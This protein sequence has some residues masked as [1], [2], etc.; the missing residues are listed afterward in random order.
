[1]MKNDRLKTLT[2]QA[3]LLSMALLIFASA[4]L[5]ERLRQS[6]APTAMAQPAPLL[7][8]PLSP[9]L[10][11]KAKQ[12]KSTEHIERLKSFGAKPEFI[13][14]LPPGIR[15]PIFGLIP[16]EPRIT[17]NDASRT[18]C[19]YRNN[20]FEKNVR[21]GFDLENIDSTA[22]P[23]I[24]ENIPME[25][26]LADKFGR[27]FLAPPAAAGEY[28]LFVVCDKVVTSIPVHI[29]DPATFVTPDFQFNN[30]PPVVN[31]F[32][33]Q[34]NNQSVVGATKNTTVTLVA[35][36]T[37]PNGD[38]PKF[39]WG[40]NAGSIVSTSG[41]TA[42]WKLPG[43]TGLNFAYVLVT[44]GKG[45][46]TE[47]GLTVSSDAGVVAGAAPARDPA[48]SDKL[49]LADHF[50]TF[51]TTRDRAEYLPAASLGAD[52]KIGSCRYYV[53]IGAASGCDDRGNLIGAQI[54]FKAW[55]QKWGLDKANAG[56]HATYANKADL[57]LERDMH[58]IT[59]AQGT[60]YYVCNYP[61]N[62]KLDVNVNLD[63]AINNKNLVACVAMEFSPTPGVS[64]NAP[65]TKFLV[66]APS[67]KLL[68]S[69]NLDGRGEKYLPGSCVVCHGAK[70][71]FNRFEEN[72]STSPDLKA[73]FL[74]FDLQNF[75]F[76]NKPG[77]TQADL[78]ASLRALNKG[79]LNTNPAPAIAEAITGWYPTPTSNFNGAFV[80]V[81]WQANPALYN[82]LV[83]PHCRTCHI[84]MPNTDSGDLSFRSLDAFRL[85]NFQHSARVCGNDIGV[86]RKRYSM[87]NSLV[88]FNR[89]WKDTTATAALRQYLIDEGELQPTDVCNPPQ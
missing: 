2:R 33:A 19:Y 46:Y 36:V 81:G 53:G 68:Q 47:A 35:N 58:G 17:F 32:L 12:Q 85:F 15:F 28:T 27:Y 87:P 8:Q 1:M 61:R 79:I 10:L 70:H 64:G 37:D 11:E 82:T 24:P 29:T 31:S 9:A 55:K 60:A 41:N 63:N 25:F 80:P 7:L 22:G 52:S 65:Y 84:S 51:F 39:T 30:A 66:F 26:Q 62:D 76:S 67:G 18:L 5:W 23:V 50:L 77:L 34:V 72:G 83:K 56:A 40:V 43:S 88:T 78:E 21:A 13:K 89:F 45:A 6:L 71:E 48:P 14:A 73:N 4:G 3:L 59:T 57:N 74:P 16:Q 44:D 20:F 42:Q 38:V 49:P 69:V 54:N 86:E 75:A